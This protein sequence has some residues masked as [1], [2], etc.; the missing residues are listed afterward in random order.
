[1]DLSRGRNERTDGRKLYTRETAKEGRGG[2]EGRDGK[3]SILEMS[4]ERVALLHYRQH[5]TQLRKIKKKTLLDD[6]VV[7]IQQPSCL[8]RG[9]SI[10][11]VG[12]A[13]QLLYMYYVLY[14]TALIH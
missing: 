1:M 5:I 10:V 13:A 2:S 6:D 12:S 8:S 9:F 11:L 14:L 3:T 4:Q 7:V